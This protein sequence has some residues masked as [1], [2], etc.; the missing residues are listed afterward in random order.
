M[1][2]GW[3][4]DVIRIF[5][6]A[7]TLNQLT[8][9]M[10]KILVRHT[11]QSPSSLSTILHVSVLIRLYNYL[12]ILRNELYLLYLYTAGNRHDVLVWFM[13]YL[14]PKN[15]Q[16]NTVLEKKKSWQNIWNWIYER[17]KKARAGDEAEWSHTTSFLFPFWLLEHIMLCYCD[18]TRL[19]SYI[20]GCASPAVLDRLALGHTALLTGL[21][22][23]SW[24]AARQAS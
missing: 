18:L 6:N 9:L 7:D 20:R 14:P 3:I 5:R 4:H 15:L 13:S 8:H 21:L 17:K 12:Y 22:D 24:F 1:F 16:W 11:L 23:S 19:W 10:L 2:H